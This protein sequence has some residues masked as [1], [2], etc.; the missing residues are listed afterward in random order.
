[1]SRNTLL[2][3]ACVAALA[4]AGPAF[5][6]SNIQGGG[7]TSSEFDYFKELALYNS[8]VAVG[9]ATFQNSDGD[10]ANDTLYWPSGSG[11]GQAAFLANNLSADCFKVLF[12]NTNPAPVQCSTG[13]TAPGG[14]NAVHYA[15]SDSPLTAAQV[16]SWST[17]AT[18][19]ATAG[20]L[21]QIPSLGTGIA[22]PVVNSKVTAN[23]ATA[24]HTPVKGGVV[25]TDNDLCGIFSGKLTNWS[26][27]SAAANLTPGL[28]TA[29]YRSD[30]AAATFLLLNHLSAVC[31]SANSNFPAATATTSG[32][33]P[34]NTFVSV[35]T[36][37]VLPIPPGGS[38][39]N[40]VGQSLSDGVAGYL[41]ATTTTSA[42]GYLTPDWT[43]VD[44]NAD[45]VLPN[46]SR[47]A[48]VV[49][50]IK[51]GTLPYIPRVADITNGLNHPNQGT[52]L[53]P[54]ATAA[55][56]AIPLNWVPVVQTTTLGYP[57]IGYTTFDLPQCYANPLIAQAIINFLTAHYSA[58]SAYAPIIARNG[59]TAI[60]STG[61][62]AFAGFISGALLTNTKKWNDNIGNVVVCK[63]LAGR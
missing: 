54:P 62:K 5:A 42:I 37:G 3:A 47:S 18:G 4:G 1:M 29:V 56:G 9:S 15:A 34:G 32:I 20:H 55:A 10:N 40:F 28:I 57:I 35:F 58:T 50:A 33:L 23:G 24:T 51:N 45:T 61:A 19:A 30:S 17:S 53:K 43:T 13:K 46:G 36:N 49:A 60:G 48:L 2:A 21:I 31:N 44:P 27:T 22:I 14:V 8:G 26:Q 6:Q 38:T 39:T 52:V 11:T 16:S 59:L 63:G 7:A 25:L 41:S 12:S